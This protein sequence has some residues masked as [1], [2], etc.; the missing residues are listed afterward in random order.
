MLYI[1]F[2]LHF[3]QILKE[4]SY[5]EVEKI[6]QRQQVSGNLLQQIGQSIKFDGQIDYQLPLKF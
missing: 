2:S 4:L 3:I 6:L 1:V 5:H